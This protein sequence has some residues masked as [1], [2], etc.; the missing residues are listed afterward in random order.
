MT[1]Y[2]ELA[3]KGHNATG[4]DS[5]RSLQCGFWFTCLF[6]ASSSDLGESGDGLDE[7][8]ALHALSGKV[9]RKAFPA[10]GEVSD[11]WLL[12]TADKAGTFGLW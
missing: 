10:V 11:S 8:Q 12:C 4:H 1:G 5:F 9:W 6:H 2:A 3:C 7:C